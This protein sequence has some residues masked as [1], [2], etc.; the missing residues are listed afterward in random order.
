[1]SLPWCRTIFRSRRYA[2]RKLYQHFVSLTDKG[3]V[4]A[5]GPTR[6]EQARQGR[7][8]R[9]PPQL[10]PPAP[11]SHEWLAVPNQTHP[12][13]RNP[14]EAPFRDSARLLVVS[15][16][17]AVDD[18]LV[19]VRSEVVVRCK[20]YTGASGASG[21]P[22]RLRERVSRDRRH[23]RTGKRSR[24]PRSRKTTRA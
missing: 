23:S 15:A 1:L 12:G 4:N 20:A 9:V 14:L 11:S 2:I 10:R 6:S 8:G 16:F 19:E 7:G 3:V 24:N 21:A 13:S 22:G 17:N 18:L 5:S